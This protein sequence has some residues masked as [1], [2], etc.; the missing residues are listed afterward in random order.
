MLFSTIGQPAIFLWMTASGVLIGVWYAFLAGLRRLTEA[1]ALL[2]LACDLLFGLGAAV[3]L[4]A[5]LITADYGR[6]RLY[7][8]LGVLLG[9]LLFA[10]GFLPLIGHCIRK[11]SMALSGIRAVVSKNRLIKVIFK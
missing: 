2:S 6:L 8:L 9:M 1:G 5:A 3:I 7:M 4:L 10:G 11:I